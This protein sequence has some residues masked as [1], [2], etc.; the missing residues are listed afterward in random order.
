MD[1][2][3]V[4]T[5]VKGLVARGS[6]QDSLIPVFV[7][8][9]AR[10]LERNY[11][12]AYMDRYYVV[13]LGDTR[14]CSGRKVLLPSEEIRNFKFV[15]LNQDGVLT[16]LNKVEPEDVSS[17]E[18]G[19]GIGAYWLD[20]RNYLWLNDAPDESTDLEMRLM[21]FTSWPLTYAAGETWLT[22]TNEFWLTVH[23]DDLLIAQTMVQI[24][25][26]L[27]DDK[28]VMTWKDLRNEALQTVLSADEEFT[29]S[30]ASMT[31]AYLGGLAS[32]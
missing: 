3:E 24:G 17:L 6:T 15:R 22:A 29:Y 23:A 31:M 9:A 19:L 25:R 1:L 5:T 10:W 18:A 21:Q 32:G 7:K 30:G 4:H 12:L 13:E 28:L 11:P 20:G 26:S 8:Q 14:F 2:G 27:R 16:Y